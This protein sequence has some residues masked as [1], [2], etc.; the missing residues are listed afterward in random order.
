MNDL[1]DYIN[2]DKYD[3]EVSTEKNDVLKEIIIKQKAKP[4]LCP[5]C[6]S[7]RL[8][9][10]PMPDKWIYCMYDNEPAHCLFKID[11][12]YCLSCNY[13]RS[14]DEFEKE[15]IGREFTESFIH[16]VIKDWLTHKEDH[17]RD[18]AEKF[19]ISHTYID[20]LQKELYRVFSERT[21][22]EYSYALLFYAFKENNRTNDKRVV[23]CTKDSAEGEKRL[24]GFYESYSYVGLPLVLNKFTKDDSNKKKTK[25]ICYSFLP[26]IGDTL[27]KH[28]DGAECV[29]INCD[30]LHD[31]VCPYLSFAKLSP[32]DTYRYTSYKGHSEEYNN[33]LNEIRE[34][35][36]I[37]N[38]ITD[39]EKK[40]VG[41]RWNELIDLIASKMQPDDK[42]HINAIKDYKV[43]DMDYLHFVSSETL[44]RYGGEGITDN[45]LMEEIMDMVANRQSYYSIA[46]KIMYDNQEFKDKII[47][48]LKEM[49]KQNRAEYMGKRLDSRMKKFIE[50]E[51][52]YTKYPFG[53]E[54][55]PTVAKMFDIWGMPEINGFS[56]KI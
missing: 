46:L 38:G 41:N 18:A 32:Q 1:N 9:C 20:T 26:D 37:E 34:V 52:G 8:S 36:T 54:T 39:E 25:V 30:E 44:E 23:I 7:K 43:H 17:L 55:E 4:L 6:G 14:E 28:F 5:R 24:L 51:R 2:S 35:L 49:T 15:I 53:F 45:P 10:S 47:D 12:I 42:L 11:D 31:D 50:D 16:N 19:G 3:I 13:R 33:L 40:A 29:A 56:R 21:Q 48:S 27:S 22:Y